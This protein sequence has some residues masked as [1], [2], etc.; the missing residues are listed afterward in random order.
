MSILIPL[1]ERYSSIRNVITLSVNYYRSKRR[2][3]VIKS[4][5]DLSDLPLYRKN[6]SIKIWV[7]DLVREKVGAK[8]RVK[9]DVDMEVDKG[10]G[11]TAFAEAAL[12]VVIVSTTIN[13]IPEISDV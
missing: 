1:F 12:H 6:F 7:K 4:H 11:I 2:T 3:T 10:I 9:E 8:A 13:F 5:T